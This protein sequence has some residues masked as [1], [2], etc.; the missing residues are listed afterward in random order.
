MRVPSLWLPPSLSQA[1]ASGQGHLPWHQRPPHT[2]A[3]T[4]CLLEVTVPVLAKG[5]EDHGADS[6]E[7]LHH[8]ELQGGLGE[9]LRVRMGQTM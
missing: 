1:F 3:G 4:R 2:P 8:T 7:R 6:H 5:L 9:K